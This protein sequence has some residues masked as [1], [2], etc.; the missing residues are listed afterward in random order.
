MGFVILDKFSKE[1]LVVFGAGDPEM[2]EVEK[3]LQDAGYDHIPATIN[4]ERVGPGNAYGADNEL[5]YGRDIIFVEC[6]VVGVT[7]D[8]VIDHHREGDPG[9]DLGPVFYWPASSIGQLVTS[10]E[11]DSSHSDRVL[12]A[13]DHC[14][15]A[16]LRGDCPGIDPQ[17]VME[18]RIKNMSQSLNVSELVICELVADYTDKIW[19]AEEELIGDGYVKDLRGLYLGIGYS[20]PKLAMGLAQALLDKPLIITE[21]NPGSDGRKKVTI[22]SSDPSQIE[23]F[24]RFWAPGEGLVDI[25]GVPNR[26]YAGAYIK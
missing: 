12:A 18:L 1:P 19:E 15:A 2:D 7:P 21:T 17:D 26:G 14:F 6:N 24:M 13:S 23:A 4:G 16:A 3:K 5:P 20:L 22:H 8:R 11:L 9:F 10:L 25:Y